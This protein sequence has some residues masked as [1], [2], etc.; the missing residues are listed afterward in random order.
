MTVS[1]SPD[2]LPPRA[3]ETAG[4]TPTQVI[5]YY[6]SQLAVAAAGMDAAMVNDMLADAEQHLWN[7]VSEGV[8]A[9]R[10]VA[11]FG[12]AADVVCAYV[13]AERGRGKGR[14]PT[15]IVVPMQSVSGGVA[16][17]RAETPLT[18]FRAVPVLGIWADRYAWG[19]MALFV[20]GFFLAI[21]YFVV[22]TAWG[23]LALGTMAMIIGFPLLVGLLGFCRVVSLAHGRLI[24]VTTGVRMPRRTAPV[25]GTGMASFWGRIGLWL[26]DGRSWLSV[27][28][29]IGNFPVAVLLFTVFF[30]L[31]ALAKSLLF[32]PIAELFMPDQWFEDGNGFHLGPWQGG[33]VPPLLGLL[34]MVLGLAIFTGALWLAKGC[35]WLYAQVAKAI[36]VT[37]PVPVGPVQVV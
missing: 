3:A 30:S 15:P 23:S 19:S 1:A 28:F 17:T 34:S 37:R 25:A 4:G 24:E 16:P 12:E 22:V 13:A 5:S 10:A 33:R 8:P 31:A 21:A 9:H 11:E 29:L 7:A 2:P 32:L 26:K 35:G 14:Q 36:Q 27:A 18:G 6:L 20:F